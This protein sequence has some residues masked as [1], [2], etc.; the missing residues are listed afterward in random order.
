MIIIDKE[1]VIEIAADF[2]GRIHRGVKIEFIPIRESREVVRQSILLNAGRQGKLGGNTFL[3]RGDS[4]DVS[5]IFIQTGFHLPHHFAEIF[6]FI[7]SCDSQRTEMIAGCDAAAAVFKIL[8]GCGCDPVDRF[9]ELSADASCS[10]QT[11]HKR[12]DQQ[13]RKHTHRHLQ[14]ALDHIR[15]QHIAENKRDI[16]IAEL[17]QRNAAGAHP[18]VK[19][20]IAEIIQTA[21]SVPGHE[22]IDFLALNRFPLAGLVCD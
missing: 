9:N 14:N 4:G 3:F 5:L 15:Q 17:A 7:I 20:G 18:A 22:F 8:S 16:I 12:S 10:D 11:D 2:L 21:V 19:V 13:T 1:E 6:N